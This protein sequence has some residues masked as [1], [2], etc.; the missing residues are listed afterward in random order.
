MQARKSGISMREPAVVKTFGG[1]IRLAVY[2]LIPS[3]I[4]LM[5]IRT[6]AIGPPG[7]EASRPELLP[8]SVPD[9]T[10]DYCTLRPAA[11]QLSLPTGTN[12]VTYS[13]SIPL[14]SRP[15]GPE[16]WCMIKMNFGLP[17]HSVPGMNK[18]YS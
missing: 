13:T 5:K 12:D 14:A 4:R 3:L 8:I 1:E 6:P 10:P 7:L 16:H 17:S 11:S 2:Q 9:S 18:S 15:R